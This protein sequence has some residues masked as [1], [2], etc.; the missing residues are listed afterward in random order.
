MAFSL[1]LNKIL[2]AGTNANVQ[3]AYIQEFVLSNI[4]SGNV[5]AGSGCV[6]PAGVYY[7]LPTANV[8]IEI[9]QATGNTNSWQVLYN[10]NTAGGGIVISDG[11]NI[12]ANALSGAAT[13]GAL[14]MFPLASEENAPGT[15]NR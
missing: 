2:I 14:T 13:F 6:I 11:Q 1:A 8:N 9:N 3:G 4:S 5:Q 10:G 12:R 7:F 15:F